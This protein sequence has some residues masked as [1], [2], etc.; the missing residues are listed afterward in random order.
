M[1]SSAHNIAVDFWGKKSA[2]CPDIQKGRIE[3]VGLEKSWASSFLVMLSI[4]I[5]VTEYL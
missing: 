5:R 4:K 3:Q 1:R 2:T